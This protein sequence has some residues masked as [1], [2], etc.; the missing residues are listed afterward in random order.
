MSDDLG[1]FFAE[2]STIEE[3][4]N[5][6]VPAVDNVTEK[7]QSQI[8]SKPAEIKSH[9]KES[10]A[11]YTYDIPDTK[12]ATNKEP[13]VVDPYAHYTSIPTSSSYNSLSYPT[14]SYSQFAQSS[15]PV[16]PP[17]EP[18]QSKT[19]VRSA[20]DEVW[21]DETLN[22]WP[23]NDYR[24]FVG[25]LGKEVTTEHL[26]K[27]FQNYKSF[28]KAKVCYVFDLIAYQKKFIYISYD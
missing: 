15:G 20:A 27:H 11:V 18:R 3:T 7:I 24:I 13:S 19:F 16:A 12:P 4:V 5:S 23:D 2:I 9:R 14:S 10:H 1:S 8:I 6:V 28:A 25:D 17:M 26:A 22:E 21:V